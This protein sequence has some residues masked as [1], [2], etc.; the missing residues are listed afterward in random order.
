MYRDWMV[1]ALQC[2]LYNLLSALSHPGWKQKKK[3]QFGVECYR[4]TLKDFYALYKV[5]PM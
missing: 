4:M 5:P 1:S 3:Q 2:Q